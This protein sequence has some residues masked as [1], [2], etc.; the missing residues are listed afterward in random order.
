MAISY[1]LRGLKLKSCA[2]M[3]AVRMPYVPLNS[4]LCINFNFT[5]VKI[6]VQTTV[7]QNSRPSSIHFIANSNHMSFCSGDNGGLRFGGYQPYPARL[8][9][10]TIQDLEATMRHSW[11]ITVHFFRR[12]A[13]FFVA[14]LINLLTSRSDNFKGLPERGWLLTRSLFGSIFSLFSTRHRRFLMVFSSQLRRFAT[15]RLDAFGF[16]RRPSAS[17]FCAL[18]SSL[19]PEVQGILYRGKGRL[20]HKKG[21]FNALSVDYQGAD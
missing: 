18:S 21:T 9:A 12:F 3:L 7:F 13:R 19:D 20:E 11:A 8:K 15:P 1:S 17:P 16:S 14:W 4:P 6:S 10:L 5:V 2:G